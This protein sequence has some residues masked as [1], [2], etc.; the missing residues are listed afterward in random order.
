M[1][2][3]SKIISFA[4][5]LLVATACSHTD[6][7]SVSGNITGADGKLLTLERTFNGHWSVVDSVRLDEK[8]KYHFESEPAGY[9]DIYRLTVDGTSAYFPVD[10]LENVTLDADLA[11]LATSYELSGSDDAR[12]MSQVNSIISANSGIL[13][14][15]VAKRELS[16]IILDNMGSIVS[17]YLINKEIGNK[18]LFSPF[19]KNDL[20]VIGAVVNAFS[21]LR[22]NDPRTRALTQS[23]LAARRAQ[24]TTTTQVEAIEIGFPEISLTGI[25]GKTHSL[26]DLTGKGRPVILNFTAYSADNSPAVNV[27]LASIYNEGGVDIYQ[28]SID[29]DEYAWREAARNLPWTTVLKSPRDGDRVL[30]DYNISSIPQSFI[31]DGNGQ[32]RE[33]VDNISDLSSLVKKYK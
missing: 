25:D 32:L 7:W 23:Y 6:K 14:D 22:P 17:Y 2:I 27:A 26:T 31:I 30:R 24:S 5:V 20:R 16:N 10:S 33:R 1:K 13:T 12:L 19:N 9:P 3:I 21:T 29:A 11:T 8:G 4:T 28:V 18:A 15:S